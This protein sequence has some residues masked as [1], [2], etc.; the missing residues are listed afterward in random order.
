MIQ[1]R[2]SDLRSLRTCCIK[3]TNQSTLLKD[4]L[5]PDPDHPKR[6]HPSK[7]YY[8]VPLEA[9]ETL[10]VFKTKFT[11]VNNRFQSK[12]LGIR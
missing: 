4:L 7:V 8:L 9:M 12:L 11:Q 5:D 1:I 2:I 6:T 3:E 10:D